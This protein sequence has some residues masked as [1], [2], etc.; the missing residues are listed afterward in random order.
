MKRIYIFLNL[1]L[2]TL[3]TFAIDPMGSRVDFDDEPD[4]GLGFLFL[5]IIGII[6][7]VIYGLIMAYKNRVKTE[8]PKPKPKTIEMFSPEWYEIQRKKDK[9]TNLGCWAFIITIA[10]FILMGIL[11]S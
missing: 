2:L 8:R 5:I 1:I 9:E 3:N 7:F 6:G 11:H 4:S 10:F